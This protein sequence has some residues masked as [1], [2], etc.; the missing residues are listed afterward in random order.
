MKIIIA[1]DSFKG[2]LSS[3]E[4]AEIVSQGIIEQLKIHSVQE[5]VEIKKIHIADGGEGTVDAFVNI[6]GGKFIK[7][8]SSGPLMERI[9]SKYGILGD[10]KTVIIDMASTCAL[11]MVEKEKRNP[12]NTTTFGMGEQII[13]ALNRGYR[14]FIIGL[15]GACTN[16]GGIGMLQALGY[17]FLD[18]NNEILKNGEGGKQL[19]IIKD[20]D[21]KM[22][23]MRLSQCQFIIAS[24]VT[25]P[26]YGKNG[27]AFTYAPQKGATPEMVIE[28]DNGLMNFA[29]VIKEKLGTE[30]SE[31]PGS[32]AAG[33]IGGGI[34]GFLN[35]KI[36]SGIELI[37]SYSSYE[38]ELK[39][40]D[41]VITGE[42]KIDKQTLN[43]KAPYII[44]K[45]ANACGIP[46]IGI[47]GKNE[48]LRNDIGMD[49]IIE[50]S[51]PNLSLEYNISCARR[52]LKIASLKI[53]EIVLNMKKT[54]EGVE[55]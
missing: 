21:L 7:C 24:D 23:D 20:I 34:M 12:M 13:D 35:G 14:N 19:G 51:N 1:V 47:C 30:I 9:N 3:S 25:N 32:G 27:A 55:I 54:R 10:K 22:V 53:G 15:G 38:N 6:T 43:G 28:L 5:K 37:L 48:L 49:S 41:L 2:C 45:K 33:G 39:T 42:G 52:Y 31:I 4:I 46:V 17:R 8:Q 11:T 29:N 40:A 50:I 36:N 26:L 44:T 18:I 16:D